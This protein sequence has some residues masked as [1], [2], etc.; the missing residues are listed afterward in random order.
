MTPNRNGLQDVSVTRSLQAG[1]S[2]AGLAFGSFVLYPREH[3]LLRDGVPVNLGSRAM[4]LLVALCTRAGAL[5]EKQELLDVVWPRAVVEECNLRAQV[6]ALR[7][8]L[9]EGGPG[10][11]IVTVPGRG[12]RFCAPVSQV[13]MEHSE[14]QAAAALPSSQLPALAVP[15]FGHERA[16][17]TVIEQ[18]SRCSLLTLTG[19]GG[20]GKTSL[21]LAAAAQWARRH[22]DRV[23]FLDLAGAG[24]PQQAK[25]MLAGLGA[26]CRAATRPAGETGGASR[27]LVLDNVEPL[28][29]TL[30][31]GLEA[32]IAQTDDLCVLVAS[33]EVLRMAAEQVYT[34]GPLASPAMDEAPSTEQAMNYPAVALFVHRATAHDPDFALAP[35]DTDTLAQ[36]CRQLDGN[37]LA[38]EMAA[39]CARTFGVQPLLSLLDGP[40]RLQMPGRRTAPERQRSLGASLDWSYAMLEDPQQAMLRHLGIFPNVFSLAALVEVLPNMTAFELAVSLEGLVAKSLVCAFEH[41]Q[42]KRYRLPRTT[43]LYARAQLEARGEAAEAG[44][45]HACYVRGRLDQ[46]IACLDTLAADQWIARYASD[47]DDVRAALQWAFAAGEHLALAVDLAMLSAPL[48][49]RLSL[50]SE[51]QTWLE[52]GLRA[53]DQARPSHTRMGLRAFLASLLTL[54]HGGGS[55]V[56]QAWQVVLEDAQALADRAHE[57]RALWGLWNDAVCSTQTGK[58][59][60]LARRYLELAQGGAVEGGAL[61]GKRML[62]VALFYQAN[63]AGARQA[64]GEA[65]AAQAA[66]RSHLI[67]LHFDQRLAARAL[68]AKVQLLEGHQGQ[69]LLGLASCLHDAIGLNHPATLWYCLCYSALPVALLVGNEVKA[70]E[71]L[72][73]LKASLS[74]QALPLWW[75]YAQCFDC[76]VQLRKAPSEGMVARLG[77]LLGALR[78]QNHTP[79]YGLFSAEHAQAL[80][81]L[82]LPQWGLDALEHSVTRAQAGEE[83]WFLAELLRV[84]ARLTLSALGP[85]GHAAAVASWRQARAAAQGQGAAFWLARVEADLQRAPREQSVG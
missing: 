5:V 35:A 68:K 46:A 79:L 1:D 6:V 19:P 59:E 54:A 26:A 36:L 57:L 10:C 62:A 30:A 61:T 32:L 85:A 60:G 70:G 82:G 63:L 58:A 38:I 2:A 18:L 69:A 65:L 28:L 11:Y 47:L 23:S 56:R 7:R 81:A 74:G 9:A 22:E 31:G 66:P 17:A 48:W 4:S 37:P 55:R 24:S 29:E 44:Q 49:L 83:R 43:L 67:D 39:A 3:V 20:I 40:F 84:K 41:E 53:L 80:A 77:E 12:Y 34:V 25:A 21:A 71:Y 42:G 8:T 78:E 16:V 72:A 27:L 52:Q 76:I 15:L 13:P 50:L 64:V 51:C 75:G 73:M 45:R 33:Q 14:Q